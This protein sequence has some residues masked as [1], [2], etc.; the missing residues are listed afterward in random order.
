MLLGH[1]LTSNHKSRKI[2]FSNRSKRV[3]D[4]VPIVKFYQWRQEFLQSWL[5]LNTSKQDYNIFALDYLNVE[6]TALIVQTLHK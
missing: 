4:H 1:K 5:Y 6:K 2:P 3:Y